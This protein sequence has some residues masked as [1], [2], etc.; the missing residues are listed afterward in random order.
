MAQSIP[1]A[2]AAPYRVTSDSTPSITLAW[3]PPVNTGGVSLTGFKL[4]SVDNTNTAVLQ[5]DGTDKPAILQYTV[6]GLSLN[7]EYGFY[8]V[9]LKPLESKPSPT[10]KY[11]VAGLPSAPGAITEIPVSRTGTSIGL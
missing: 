10:V 8:I 6:T 3:S 5:F 7:A 11:T 1:S 2:P 9:A 4:Y